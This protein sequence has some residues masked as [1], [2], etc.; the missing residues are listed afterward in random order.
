VDED[1]KNANNAQ[2]AGKGP[3]EQMGIRALDLTNK[4]RAE[5]NLPALR[6]NQEIH[7]IAW[8]HSKNMGDGK[9]PFSH[10][11]FAERSR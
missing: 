1:V 4:F 5:H 6:W 7:N 11:G 3:S 9:V 8:G 10:D 2:S